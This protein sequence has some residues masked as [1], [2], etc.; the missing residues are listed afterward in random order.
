LYANLQQTQEYYEELKQTKPGLPTRTFA[1]SVTL[2]EGGREIQILQ[3]G[4]GHTD[5][6]VFIYL[7]REKVVA[8]GDAL[9][10]WMPFLNDSFPEDWVETLTQ[11][12][13]VDFAHVIPG[14][15]E[16]LPKTQLGFFRGYLTEL[17]AAVKKA[18]A[19]GAGLDEMKKGIADQL[20][21][22]YEHGMSKY[23]LGQYRDRIGLNVEM[24][25]Q[26][27]VKKS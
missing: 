8:S 3:L 27:V 6:D 10:D 2:D 19:D 22:K 16:V 15:G 17:I 7:P 4:R 18:S 23:P 1:E 12:E 14:H 21:A 5:G 13:Q 20:A 25:Y 24:V 9:I 26:K 11:L